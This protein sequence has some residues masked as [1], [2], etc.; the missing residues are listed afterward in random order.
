MIFL[1][2]QIISKGQFVKTNTITSL[3]PAYQHELTIHVDAD[4]AHQMAPGARIIVY[5]ITATGEVIN[6]ALDFNVDGAFL[7]EV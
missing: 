5:Y 4:L 2:F 6:D 7:N 1:Y 3:D